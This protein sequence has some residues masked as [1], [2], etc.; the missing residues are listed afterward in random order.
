MQFIVRFEVRQPANVS[1]AEL[2]AIWRREADA[3]MAAVEAGAVKHLWKVSGQRVVFAIVEVE[4]H[5]DL[6]RA[7][8]GLPIFRELG[9]G[10]STEALPI[11][12]YST[13]AEDLHGGVHGG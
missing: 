10:V 1:N 11:Y 13:F 6:D 3:A 7:L 12:D 8:G 5:A 4:S 2:V 9:A